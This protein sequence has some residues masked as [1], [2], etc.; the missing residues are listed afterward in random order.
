MSDR[1]YQEHIVIQTG[2]IDQSEDMIIIND[3]LTKINNKLADILNTLS[4]QQE[5]PVSTTP[6]S[7][8]PQL[9]R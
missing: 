9:P 6:Y 5:T 4:G 8:I 1:I 2:T 3:Q 7:E